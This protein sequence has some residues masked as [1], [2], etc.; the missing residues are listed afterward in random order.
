MNI[1]FHYKQ[2]NE[3]IKPDVESYVT[4]KIEDLQRYMPESPEESVFATVNIERYEKHDAYRVNIQI[5]VR[6]GKEVIF[7]AEETKHTYTESIDSVKDKLQMQILKVKD[8]MV[9]RNAA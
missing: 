9:D 4:S 1:K 5:V 2:I 3:V 6:S 7:Q 8:K